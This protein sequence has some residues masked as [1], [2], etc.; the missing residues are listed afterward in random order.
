MI[1]CTFRHSVRGLV[2]A[3]LA[4]ALSGCQLFDQGSPTAPSPVGPPAPSEPIHYTA[5]GASDANGVGSSEPCLPFASCETG[6]GYVPVLARQLRASR[7]VTVMNL[8]FPASVLSPA[9]EAV[10]RQ[11]GREVTGNFLE[12]QMPF[13]EPSSTLVTIFG[14]GNDANAVGDAMEQGAAGDDVAG[15]VERQARAFGADFDRL[16]AGVRGRA[17]QSFI[18]VINVP[19][20]ALLPYAGG[21][22]LEHRRALQTLSVAFTREANRQARAGVVVLDAM[23]DAALYAPSNFSSDGFHPSDAGYAHLASRLAAIVNGAASTP[24]A[25]CASMTAVP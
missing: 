6:M 10:A 9:I 1:M 17:P 19:N 13:V 15:Y 22:P 14:G 7:Q 25:S 3:V 23:C 8:G 18:I 12:G 24:A 16:I 21:Y 20:L 4:L 5:I 11:H 2:P